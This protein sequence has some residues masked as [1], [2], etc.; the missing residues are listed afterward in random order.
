MKC[1][2]CQKEISEADSLYCPYCGKK[3]T[4]GSVQRGIRFNSPR[5]AIPF[6]WWF[7]VCAPLA[8]LL[9]IAEVIVTNQVTEGWAAFSL[10]VAA[11][12]IYIASVYVIYD[13]ARRHGRN[14]VAWTTAAIVFSPILAGI[15]Y[16]L[17]WPKGD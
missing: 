14:A 2:H 5:A 1:P 9:T 7:V 16:G 11:P 15:A 17:T 6:L 13:N 12:G 3:L 10:F 8:I 4:Q